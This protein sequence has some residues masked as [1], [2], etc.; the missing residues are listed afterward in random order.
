MACLFGSVAPGAALKNRS[1]SRTGQFIVYCD[2][3]ELRSRV[4]S[5][6][7]ELKSDALQLLR[8]TDGWSSARAPIVVTIDP[9]EPGGKVPPAQVRWVNTVAGPKI[10]VVVRVGNDPAQVYLQSHLLKAILLEISYR[11]GTPPSTNQ[12]Y[13]EPPWWLVEGILEAI[14]T[15]NGFGGADIFKSIVNTEKLPSLERFLA[16]PPLHLD[17]AAGAVDR[18]CAMCLV[19]ALLALPNGAANLVRFIETWPASGGDVQAALAAQFPVL[20]GTE[21]ALAKWWSLHLARFAAGDRT[22]GMSLEETD[23]QLAGLLAFEIPVDKAGRM[24]RY[25]VRDFPNFVKLPAAKIA[26]QTQQVKVVALMTGAHP[27]FRPILVEY[28]QILSQLSLKKTRRIAE[29]L[30]EIERYRQTIMQQMGQITDY[31][32]WYEATQPAGRTG[33]FEPYIRR[34]EKMAEPAP[35]DPRITEYLDKLEQ[36]FAPIAP[37][38]FPGITPAGAASR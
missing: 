4:V 33:V 27:L 26:L 9:A 23:R 20:A 22:L 7:E 12:A 36:D 24:Q 34:A 14:R 19:E 38:A 10:D 6:A 32:N 1:T 17:T 35:V 8:E 16:Q 3:R 30:E 28:E 37:N 5:F 2:D 31:L 11:H 15:R 21:H 13:A 29:R 25:E 18:A